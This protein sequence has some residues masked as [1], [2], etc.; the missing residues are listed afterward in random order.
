MAQSSS[1]A[2]NGGEEVQTEFLPGRVC[3]RGS[4]NHFGSL[5]QATELACYYAMNESVMTGVA[6]IYRKR[7][8]VNQGG[9]NSL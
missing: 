8:G 5:L 7:V 4:E 3:T 9:S 1:L 6:A 2:K